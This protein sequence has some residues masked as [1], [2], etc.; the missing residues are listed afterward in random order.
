MID[1]VFFESSLFEPCLF[2]EKSGRNLKDTYSMANKM[3]DQNKG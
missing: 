3:G 2:P 1:L